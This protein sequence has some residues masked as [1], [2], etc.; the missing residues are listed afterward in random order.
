[1]DAP[2]YEALAG[3]TRAAQQGDVGAYGRIVRRTQSLVNAVVRRVVA[4][5][6]TA[7]D[8]VQETYLRAYLRLARLRDP[9]SLVAWLQRIARGA[10]LNHVRSRRWSFVHDVDVTEFPAPEGSAVEE[11]R[12]EAARV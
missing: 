7:E 12:V 11:E 8:V 2:D 6:Q 3:L 1:M 10:A 9:A 5:P 4:D